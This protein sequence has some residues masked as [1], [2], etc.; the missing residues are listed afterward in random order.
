MYRRASAGAVCADHRARFIRNGGTTRQLNAIL[1]IL[2]RVRDATWAFEEVIATDEVP[3][4]E[5]NRELPQEAPTRHIVQGETEPRIDEKLHINLIQWRPSHSRVLMQ[6]SVGDMFR[7]GR[8]VVIM[9]EKHDDYQLRELR[10]LLRRHGL[11]EV[12]DKNR[13]VPVYAP[14]SWTSP[15]IALSTHRRPCSTCATKVL[16]LL[17]PRISPLL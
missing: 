10:R 1:R 4:E 13:R 11:Q 2:A 8:G 17:I 9:P 14:S 3:A 16:P 6:D 5:A 12:A 15:L 7:G